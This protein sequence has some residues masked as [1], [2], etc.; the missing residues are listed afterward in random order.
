[1]RRAC[2]IGTTP[3]FS[4]FGPIRRTSLTRMVSFTR[5]FVVLIVFSLYVIRLTLRFIKVFYKK[6]IPQSS[7]IR[8]QILM[9]FLTLLLTSGIFYVMIFNFGAKMLNQPNF[10]IKTVPVYGDLILAPM[11]GVSSM[12]FRLLCHGFGS[13]MSYTEFVSTFDIIG[14][15]PY[16]LED[17]LTYSED[18]R[19]IVFQIFDNDPERIL[20]AALLVRQRNP[21][22]I[23]INLGCSTRKVSNRGAGAGL[24]KTPEKIARIFELLTKNLDIPITGKIRLGWDDN[25]R[26]YMTIARI[27]EDNGCALIAFH[28]RTKEQLYSGNA[29]WD[30]IA[31]LKQSVS[32][33]VI[34]NGDVRSSADIERI[35]SYTGCNGV[36]IGRAAI[37]NPW[38]FSHRDRH[39][40]QPGEAH[41]TIHRH[42]KS[43]VEFYGS[44]IG[45]IL[46]RKFIT[47]YV[48][49]YHLKR[50]ERVEL[51]TCNEPDAFLPLLDKLCGF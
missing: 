50:A 13:A 20:K 46:F 28:A 14:G 47:P 4:P 10:F 26:N 37:A 32:I 48:A 35:K 11:A 3:T 27:L 30:A 43:H 49:P 22:I 21:D 18:E 6:I 8:Q 12:P 24:L 51:L 44:R 5:K 2:S 31:E 25:N 34:A 33:P 40:I 23:D 45:I 1:M 38:I 16:L 17:R 39:E 36:M 29:D 7:E 15:H 42:F 41:E 9:L 19:P